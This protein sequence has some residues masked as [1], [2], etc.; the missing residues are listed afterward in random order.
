MRI[1]SLAPLLLVLAAASPL[2]AQRLSSVPAPQTAIVPEA[3]TVGD[4][5]HAAIRVEAPPGVRVF[6]PDTLEVPEEVEAAGRR[7]VSVDTVADKLIYTAAYPLTAWR[8]D[9]VE[10]RAA[11]VQLVT[12]RGEGRVAASF[13]AFAIQSVLPADTSGIE[14]KPAKDVLGAMRLLWP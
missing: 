1:A 8:P 9:T 7:V 11:R 12:E 5:F 2:R 3:I 14:P 10:L 6:F 13:P 4:V